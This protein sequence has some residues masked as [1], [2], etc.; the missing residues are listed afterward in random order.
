M[1]VGLTYFV[2]D[3]G[4]GWIVFD[5]PGSSVNIFDADTQAAFAS[6]ITAMTSRSLKALILTSAKERIFSAG[7]D[8]R[9]LGSLPDASTAENFS[10]V[11]QA[12][13]QRVASFPVPVVGA[14][15]GA[16]AGGG[17]ELALAC[18][19]RIA[20]DAPATRIGL[21]ELELGTIPGWGG[22]ARLPRLIG[23]MP[24]LEHILNAQLLPSA[25]A[26]KT[27]IVD[28]LASPD[29]LKARA[30]AIALQL[31]STGK[32]TR[33]ELSAP[34]KSFFDEL[35]ACERSGELWSVRSK[36]IDV[37][38][39]GLGLPLGD[40]LDIEARAFGEVTAGAACKDRVRAFFLR[41]RPLRTGR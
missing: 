33:P 34:A 13:F 35:R 37:V 38:Q 12:L 19:W 20:S 3:G 16:C 40:A 24:A 15:H 21:P 31:G 9:W 6:A 39:L 11:G 25:I 18:H 8:L 32:P 17:L 29:E 30:R 4:V 22:S 27:G 1:S 10:R 23:A 5:A 7:A 26:L 28:E 36:L 14:I 2:D 41:R